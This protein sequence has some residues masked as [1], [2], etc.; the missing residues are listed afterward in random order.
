MTIQHEFEISHMDVSSGGNV[1]QVEGTATA[2]TL[3][4]LQEG[5]VA[6]KKKKKEQYR[7][8]WKTCS[9]I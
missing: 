5:N 1:C 6:G 9:T 8:D 3:S 4:L 2:N 7:E